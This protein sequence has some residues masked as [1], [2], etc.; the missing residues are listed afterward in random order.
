M[1]T[2][3]TLDRSAR[4]NW[5]ERRE[6]ASH[7][8]QFSRADAINRSRYRSAARRSDRRATSREKCCI[9]RARMFQQALRWLQQGNERTWGMRTRDTR[10]SCARRSPGNL[11]QADPNQLLRLQS[12]SGASSIACVL[13]SEPTLTLLWT[14]ACLT[15]PG[16]QAL[17]LSRL[18]FQCSYWNSLTCVPLCSKFPL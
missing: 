3:S 18:C 5:R 8:L 17:P 9:Y 7:Y 16:S 1:N 10:S 13:Y 14:W 15:G 4:A 2:L 6:S 11:C 12:R